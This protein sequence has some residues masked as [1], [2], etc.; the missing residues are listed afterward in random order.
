VG[1]GID[2]L[3]GVYTGDVGPTV[4]S[5]RFV[6]TGH[7]VTGE[8]A[9]A[10]DVLEVR[11]GR[12]TRSSPPPTRTW[13][14]PRCSA[15]SS[16]TRRSGCGGR[17][18]SCGSRPGV[19]CVRRSPSGSPDGADR[20]TRRA[21]D[22]PCEPPRC[23]SERDP[24]LTRRPPRRAVSA[25]R[26]SPVAVAARRSRPSPPRA[27]APCPLVVAAPRPRGGATFVSERRT[28]PGQVARRRARLA[29]PPSRRSSRGSNGERIA[30]G[31]GSRGDGG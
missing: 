10:D 12:P 6:Y 14:R 5:V 4:R 13:W 9:A 20:A 2:G 31:S 25:A 17:R 8:P 22:G 28:A 19:E 26:A 7:L 16:P 24:G 23:R 15:G 3:L 27:R 21:L 1:I 18:A 29:A 30:R 11:C